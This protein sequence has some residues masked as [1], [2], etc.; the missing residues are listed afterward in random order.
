M[1]AKSKHFER[2]ATTDTGKGSWNVITDK[3]QMAA[4]VPIDGKVELSGESMYSDS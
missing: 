4:M 2:L 1:T 3:V